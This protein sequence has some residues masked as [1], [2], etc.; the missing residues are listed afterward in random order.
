MSHYSKPAIQQITL[1]DAQWSDCPD[2]V[3]EEVAKIWQ[4]RELPNDSS[5][6]KWKRDE[7]YWGP[8]DEDESTRSVKD[9]FP[10]LD[11]Y[12]MDQGISE[13]WIHWWW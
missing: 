10:T 7:E 6:Y 5:I 2:E 11:K 12:L 13:C 1:L 4:W 8:E 9:V 3:K